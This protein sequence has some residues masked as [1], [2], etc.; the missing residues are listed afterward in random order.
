[1]NK[2]SVK[3][4]GRKEDRQVKVKRREIRL[5]EYVCLCLNFVASKC[6][7]ARYSS[8]VCHIFS[9]AKN[10]VKT[11]E[12]PPLCCCPSLWQLHLRS[13]LAQLMS[14]SEGHG[15]HICRRVRAWKNVQRTLA[16]DYRW[17]K[18]YFRRSEFMEN[19]KK[20]SGHANQILSVF[21]KLEMPNFSQSIRLKV[22]ALISL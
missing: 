11:Y 3:F 2:A 16:A 21:S 9:L 7:R 14:C 1:M 4:L 13:I 15:L 18:C 12:G 8:H 5:T 10:E 17:D 22:Q 20:T 6:R 19:L